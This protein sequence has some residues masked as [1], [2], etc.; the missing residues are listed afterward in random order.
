MLMKKGAVFIIL[1]LILVPISFAIGERIK[2]E[3]STELIHEYASEQEY[4]LS[5]VSLYGFVDWSEVSPEDYGKVDWSKVPVSGYPFIDWARVPRDRI[6]TIP[7]P[8]VPSIPADVVPIPDLATNQKDDL[9]PEQLI[10]GGNLQDA[11]DLS[12]L[13]P[14]HLETAVESKFGV[15]FPERAGMGS[16]LKTDG[17]TITN[18]HL[19]F[20]NDN[21]RLIIPHPLSKEAESF[22]PAIDFT[23]SDSDG[24][25][26]N[27]EELNNLN[28]RSN[29]S[30]RDGLSDYEEVMLAPTDPHDKNSL[31]NAITDKEAVDKMKA[32]K[33]HTFNYQDKDLFIELNLKDNPFKD[34]DGD[35]VSDLREY[36]QGTQ[37]KN[38]DSDNDSWSDGFEIK[39]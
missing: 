38:R 24:L 1:I 7:E 8:N 17:A 35:G 39:Q 14:N 25:S 28:P 36:I 6:S 27:F 3:K 4:D 2:G 32:G 31:S 9:I 34:S 20:A 11:G 26:D 37:I 10:H 19:V 23:D 5:D 29:D 30:D 12:A 22:T 15:D 16:S 18:M 13:N 21:D 33:V